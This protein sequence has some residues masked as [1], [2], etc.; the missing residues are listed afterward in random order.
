VSYE[1]NMETATM[2]AHVKLFAMP[3]RSLI[4]PDVVAKE[5][6]RFAKAV[7]SPDEKPVDP[8]AITSEMIR[9]LSRWM[10]KASALRSEEVE[11][12]EWLNTARK[13]GWRYWKRYQSY[14]SKRLPQPV[15][16]ALDDATD[17]IMG[18]LHDPKVE[19]SWDRRGLVVGHVQSGKTG[20]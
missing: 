5:V 18:S 10:A 1:D 16:A 9:R 13:E 14:L 7:D 11:H 19:G 6:A 4:T 17:K 3:D 12:D 2:L 15:I 20:N 8:D